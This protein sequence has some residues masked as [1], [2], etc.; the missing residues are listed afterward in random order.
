VRKESETVHNFRARIWIMPIFKARI[1][2]KQSFR[3]RL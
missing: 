2:E 1:C 3:V